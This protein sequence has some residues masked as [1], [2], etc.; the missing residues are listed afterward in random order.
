[1]KN[2]ATTQIPSIKIKEREIKNNKSY[3]SYSDIINNNLFKPI[4]NDDLGEKNIFFNINGQDF[5]FNNHKDINSYLYINSERKKIHLNNLRLKTD[6]QSVDSKKKNK[7]YQYYLPV[8]MEKRIDKSNIPLYIKDKKP[9]N[10]INSLKQSVKYKIKENDL[11]KL[12][13][14]LRLNTISNN[15]NK[16]KSLSTVKSRYVNNNNNN[17]SLNKSKEKENNKNF[18][19]YL[20]QIK[21]YRKRLKEQMVN[22]YKA[23]YSQHSIKKDVE[24]KNDNSNHFVYNYDN[25]SINSI[26]ENVDKALNIFYGKIPNAKISGY[27]KAFLN[28]SNF[29]TEKYI[30]NDEIKKQL[31][32]ININLIE[33]K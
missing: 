4:I 22:R 20:E 25:K 17:K 19:D 32:T 7:K 26:N 27:E 10:K 14:S 11:K 6:T 15:H 2:N 23:Q 8:L 12:S 28:Y 18:E 5:N 16:N 24:N 33:K 9:N 3:N 13:I 30:L 31:N 21:N 29:S 1:M